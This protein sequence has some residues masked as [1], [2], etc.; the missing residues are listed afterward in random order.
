MIVLGPNTHFNTHDPI[1][2]CLAQTCE[3]STHELHPFP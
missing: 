1:K 2:L 3:K